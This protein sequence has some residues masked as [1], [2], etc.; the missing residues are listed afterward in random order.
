MWRQR[1]AAVLGLREHLDLTR[2]DE[3]THNTLP[4]ERMVVGDDD[5]HLLV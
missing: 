5:S 1:L 4:V 2:G 3:R